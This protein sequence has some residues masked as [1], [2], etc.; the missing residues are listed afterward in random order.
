MADDF[1]REA[2]RAIARNT[3][4][5]VAARLAHEALRAAGARKTVFYR[6]TTRG[7]ERVGAFDADQWWADAPHVLSPIPDSLAELLGEDPPGRITM[8]GGWQL[9]GLAGMQAVPMMAGGQA[10]GV[11]L[12]DA[13]DAF[14]IG[15]AELVASTVGACLRIGSDARELRRLRE[16]HYEH[17]VRSETL[18][19]TGMLSAGVAHELNNPLGVV[20]GLA[21]L[22]VLD[23]DLPEPARED[24]KVIVEE[25]GRAV[26]VV[27]Q[28]LSYGRGGGVDLEE[29]D[30]GELVESCAVM[31]EAMSHTLPVTVERDI[32]PG[33]W[34]VMAD[35]FRL[36]Q[37]FLAILDNARQ[38][39]A[40]S[41]LDKGRIEISLG[42][43]T[44]ST[45]WVRISDDGPGIEDEA[46]ARLFDPFFTTREVGQGTG[47]GLALV[48][49]TVRDLGGD[50]RCQNL[51]QGGACFVISL[52][53]HTTP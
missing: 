5:R 29:V 8:Q 40:D 6:L 46:L 19:A 21:E 25:T 52:D 45:I 41:G 2:L 4:P 42:V 10:I 30:L 23:D 35:A 13:P 18:A 47:M 50:I 15:D 32:P 51:D 11:V 20:V 34:L 27:Q 36:Q 37:A 9:E 16:E 26:R 53:R 12:V 17:I 39:I 44:G 48:H 31:L 24:L 43:G 38:A 7:L 14:R 1:P 49:R 33:P 22:L 28:L 3:D